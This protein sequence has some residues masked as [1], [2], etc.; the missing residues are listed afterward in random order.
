MMQ[1]NF[2]YATETDSETERTGAAKCDGGWRGMDWE[3]GVSRCKRLYTEWVNN[4]I[5]LYSIGNYI[6]IL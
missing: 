4:K 6:N 5:L 1:V 3:F 2:I